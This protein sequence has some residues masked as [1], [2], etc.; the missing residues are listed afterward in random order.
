MLLR[1]E[2]IILFSLISSS[3]YFWLAYRDLT[4]GKLYLKGL[5]CSST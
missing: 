3:Q 5:V 4:K 1:L 2:Y